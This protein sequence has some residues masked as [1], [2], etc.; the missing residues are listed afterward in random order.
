MGRHTR[1]R[2]GRARM[3]REDAG[4][5]EGLSKEREVKTTAAA[6]RQRAPDQRREENSSEA[7]SGIAECETR[8]RRIHRSQESNGTTVKIKPDKYSSIA[9]AGGTEKEDYDTR[10]KGESESESEKVQQIDMQPC[11]MQKGS[12][13]GRATSGT[14]TRKTLET[15]T[16]KKL[17]RGHR[18]W[19][20][21]VGIL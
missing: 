7:D 20:E 15:S 13:K 3:G 17:R 12:R 6:A 8:R 11:S 2:E 1:E 9:G 16:K 5:N 18:G 14:G 19:G 4:D 10:E 21:A